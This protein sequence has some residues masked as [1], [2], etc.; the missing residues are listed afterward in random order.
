M[1]QTREE[2][3]HIMNNN[4]KIAIVGWHD[5]WAGIL[6]AWLTEQK[7]VHVECFVHPEDELP[8]IDVEAHKKK[9]ETRFFDYP[10]NGL[11]KG[12]PLLISRKW[13]SQLKDRGIKKVVI[14]YHIQQRCLEL[15]AEAKAEELELISAIHP[16]VIIQEEAI[17]H[18]GVMIGAGAIIGYRTEIHPGVLVNNGAQIDHHCVIYPC[19]DIN[20]GV[21]IASN[22]SIHQC[23]RVHTGATIINSIRIGEEAII[24]A[25][26]V[27]IDDVPP[28]TTV[29]GVP[30]KD[31]A[32]KTSR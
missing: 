19:V 27:V 31:I 23:S 17:I 25:G 32:L 20:P 12:R 30:A 13:A 8:Y 4:E 10:I 22:V 2:L 16:T 7:K 18:P 11:F 3:T 24:G 21:V 14:A 26:A 6:H 1:R 5:G 15:I 9:T 29:V 28:K